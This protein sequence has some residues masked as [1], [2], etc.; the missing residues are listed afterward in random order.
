MLFERLRERL[1]PESE[2]VLAAVTR[3]M[4]A[5]RLPFGATLI[6]HELLVRDDPELS[7][8]LRREGVS[9]QTVLNHIAS[10][11]WLSAGGAGDVTT[12][13][14]VV[15]ETLG[16]LSWIE[17]SDLARSALSGIERNPQNPLRPIVFRGRARRRS[18]DRDA[19]R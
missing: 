11:R 7:D 4:K 12:S 8:W 2:E 17:T 13:G 1:A 9:P 15:L 10:S 16:G 5:E 14:K 19:R 3:R 18:P 6:V